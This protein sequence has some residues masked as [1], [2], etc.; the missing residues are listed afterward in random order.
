MSAFMI[1]SLQKGI[2]YLKIPNLGYLDTLISP[3]RE[4]IYEAR[5]LMTN[6][7]IW[8]AEAKILEGTG[9]VSMTELTALFFPKKIDHELFERNLMKIK[10]PTRSN[11]LEFWFS[12]AL[13]LVQLK[14]SGMQSKITKDSNKFPM[15]VRQNLLPDQGP[16]PI[17]RMIQTE[18]ALQ[19]ALQS[20]HC[21]TDAPP[22]SPIFWPP[23][24]RPR[25]RSSP[26]SCWAFLATYDY[27][28][29]YLGPSR[30]PTESQ[31]VI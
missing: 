25:P 3:F 14:R 8:H 11:E 18:M 20:F 31:L 28:D 16:L 17:L 12:L 6:N 1:V 15:L 2:N 13:L 5:L 9:N 10:T 7:D 30:S 24:M 27:S 26:I 29:D 23:I 22:V 19:T 4:K 21:I